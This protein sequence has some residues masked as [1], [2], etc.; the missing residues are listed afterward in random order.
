[1]SREE[2]QR[3]LRQMYLRNC[4]ERSEHGQPQFENEDAYYRSYSNWLRKKFEDERTEKL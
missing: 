2:F 4:K 3:S 1:M